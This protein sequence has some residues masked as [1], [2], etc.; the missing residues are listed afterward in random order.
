LGKLFPVR[1][2]ACVGPARLWIGPVTAILI[3]LMSP[4]Q[5]QIFWQNDYPDDYP[6]VYIEE[7]P[8]PLATRPRPHRAK[9]HHRLAKSESAAKVARKPQGPIIIAISIRRQTLKVYDANGLFAETPVSTGMRGHSTPMGV[10]S[11]IQ[12]QKWHRSNIYSG[13]PMPYMQRITWS[14]IAM[15]AGVLPGYPASHGCI[16]MP[17]SF[18][19]KMW[20]WTR[21]GAR[22]II[23][24]GEVTPAEFSHPLLTTHRPER[25]PVAAEVLTANAGGAT[26]QQPILSTAT[27]SPVAGEPRTAT[28]EPAADPIKADT[29]NTKDA[30]VTAATG[31]KP[32]ADAPRD[33]P[34]SAGSAAA[35]DVTVTAQDQSHPSS[36]SDVNA[37]SVAISELKRS[38]RIAVFVS[39]KD[40]KIYV[41]QNF[42][43]LF[44]APVTI[45]PSDRPLGTHVFTAEADKDNK[46]D[47]RWS[48]VS[49]PATAHRAARVHVRE[50]PSRERADAKSRPAPVPDSAADALDRISLPED[51]MTKIA[52]SLSTGDSIVVSDQG[53]AGGETGKGTDFIIKLQ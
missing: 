36:A 20:R 40:G 25:A 2:A 42:A 45:T 23:T 11:I 7:P 43:P 44:D 6:E 53:I 33:K 14:G 48:V 35:A 19:V 26:V 41:R 38:D 15:H 22:V 28:P 12:K 13:A 39:R 27:D 37:E 3:G 8:P 50:N 49:L 10:F 4:A 5:S 16:R 17:M 47:F 18:A 30:D 1:A 9:H 46:D 31:V 24:P 32:E 52:D 29:D 51:V 21:I 34:Q